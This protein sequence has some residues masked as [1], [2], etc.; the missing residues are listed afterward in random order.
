MSRLL[1]K[2]SNDFKLKL[3][4]TDFILV[5][6]HLFV[7]LAF[8]TI[9]NLD[10]TSGTNI[11]YWVFVYY[12]LVPLALVGLFFRNLRNFKLYLIWIVIG[13]IQLIIYNSVKDIP[14]F[15]FLM[16]TSFSGLKALL[17]TLLVYQIF[18]LVFFNLR[19]QEMIVTLSQGRMTMW[20]DEENRNMTWIE[21]V[22]SLLLLGTILLF[23]QV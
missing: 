1:N 2:I 6:I 4:V 23:N 10:L 13:V 22:F 11:K 3:G 17:P 20:E 14:D 5:S 7:G 16:G 18:R 12:F 19:G 9:Y 15:Q 8:W 21:V